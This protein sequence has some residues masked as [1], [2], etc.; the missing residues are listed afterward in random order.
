[1]ITTDLALLMLPVAA[2]SGWCISRISQQKEDDDEPAQKPTVPRDYFVGLNYLLNEQP[3]KAVDV[4]VKMLEVDSETV[5]THLAL[6]SLFRRRGEVERA[7]RIH[8]NLIARPNLSRQMRIQ[9]LLELGQDYLAAGVFDRAERIFKEVVASGE[10]LGTSLQHLLDIYQQEKNWSDAI[11]IAQRI[12]AATGIKMA[13]AISHYH[14]ELATLQIKQ[15]QYDLAY[16]HLRKALS[17]DKSCARASILLGDLDRQNQRYKVAIRYFKQ[18]VNQDSEYL[19]EILLPLELCYV[20]LNNKEEFLSYLYKLLEQYPRVSIILLLAERIA[21]N[22]GSK[23]AAEFV[24][25]QMRLHPSIQG[26]NQL[27][28]LHLQDVKQNSMAVLTVL[29]DISEKLLENKPIYQCGLCGFSA[30]TLLWLCPGCR[31]WSTIKPIHGLEGE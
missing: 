24:T 30:N 27:I 17:T 12:E 23:K 29:Q 14:C 8:Q 4:F 31:S 16:R 2:F 18:V 1:M 28:Q 9:S 15:S 10:Y 13:V 7:T 3:D 26:L 19:T 22:E 5:E 20:A 6:G 11:D 25:Q 21:V